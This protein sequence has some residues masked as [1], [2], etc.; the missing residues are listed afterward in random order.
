MPRDHQ[1][2]A[3]LTVRTSGLCGQCSQG[4]WIDFERAAITIC[5]VT[6]PAVPPMA[7]TR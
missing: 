2:S 7:V 1:G 5:P 4:P 3:V 6:G